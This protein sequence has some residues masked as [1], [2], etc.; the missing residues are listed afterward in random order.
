MY[1]I[2]LSTFIGLLGVVN[3]A[4]A[5]RASSTSKGVN[6]LVAQSMTPG[7]Y[8]SYQPVSQGINMAIVGST[9]VTFYQNAT[10]IDAQVM[11]DIPGVYPMGL[12]IQHP[13]E[14]D[15]SYPG[16]HAVSVNV[17][18][19]TGGIIVGEQLGGPPTVQ[20]SYMVCSREYSFTGTPTTYRVVRYQFP[21]EAVPDG[22]T[23]IDFMSECATLNELP[24]DS[25]WDHDSAQTVPCAD[26]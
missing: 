21:G 2:A 4:P 1:T 18:D 26:F 11:T 10:G 6:F 12:H 7:S 14:Y 23:P 8:L 16:E 3:A 19:V 17:N 24:P 5:K 13:D 20:G 25:D 15:A 9:P 22:C